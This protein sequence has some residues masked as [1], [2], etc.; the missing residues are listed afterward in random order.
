[1]RDRSDPR[2]ASSR[3]GEPG[4]VFVRVHSPILTLSGNPLLLASRN[5]SNE[6]PLCQ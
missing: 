1:M 2:H 3:H 5:A 6:F 4:P